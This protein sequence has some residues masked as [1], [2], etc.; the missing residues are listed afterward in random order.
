MISAKTGLTFEGWGRDL[1]C[2][3]TM[4]PIAWNNIKDAL[5]K[6]NNQNGYT[7]ESNAVDQ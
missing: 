1:L 7:S 5:R 3:P 4:L 2:F 6:Q